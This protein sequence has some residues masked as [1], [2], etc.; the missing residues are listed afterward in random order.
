MR[1]GLA[2]VPRLR[3]YQSFSRM[4][5]S[6]QRMFSSFSTPNMGWSIPRFVCDLIVSFQNVCVIAMMCR[7]RRH[8]S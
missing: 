5:P 8:R 2:C 7:T 6:Q 1:V 3:Q 4:L